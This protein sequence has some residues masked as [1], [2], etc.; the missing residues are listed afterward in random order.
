[1]SDLLDGTL[2]GWPVSLSIERD[3]GG[4]IYGG[5]CAAYTGDDD[6]PSPIEIQMSCSAI[7]DTTHGVMTRRAILVKAKAMG[8]KPD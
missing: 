4:K 5:H 8:F 7:T 6:E 2:D 3:T 1:M